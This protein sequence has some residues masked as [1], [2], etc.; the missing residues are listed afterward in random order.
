MNDPQFELPLGF[1]TQPVPKDHRAIFSTI[2]GTK[3]MRALTNPNRIAHRPVWAPAKILHFCNGIRSRFHPQCKYLQPLQ[4]WSDLY[5]YFDAYDIHLHGAWNLWNVIHR[6]I[7]ENQLLLE[8][9]KEDTIPHFDSWA[10]GL[11]QD[12]DRRDRLRT[13]NPEVQNDII[14][15]FNV[16]ELSDIVG[17]D[18][19]YYPTIRNILWNYHIKL[20]NELDAPAS[21]DMQTPSDLNA[22]SPHSRKESEEKTISREGKSQQDGKQPIYSFHILNA[23]YLTIE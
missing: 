16:D 8:G 6:M 23:D 2:N 22:K 3:P 13:W 5:Q 1:F 15:C 12:K 7:S 11:I 14:D 18:P 4:A 21:A 10:V 20:C 17:L 19:F 9:L